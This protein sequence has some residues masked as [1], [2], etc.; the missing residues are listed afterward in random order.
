MNAHGHRGSAGTGSAPAVSNAALVKRLLKLAWVYRLSCVRVLA[1]Q[2]VLLAVGLSGLSLMGTGVDYIRYEAQQG[3]SVQS[4]RASAVGAAPETVPAAHPG[5]AKPPRWPLGLRP[6]ADWSRMRVLFALSGGILLLSVFR[7]GLSIV[8]TLLNNLF[9]Q[10]QLVADLRSRV[11][12]K[13]QRL[14]FKFFDANASGSLINRVTGDAQSVRAF[15]EDAL[16]NGVNLVVSL[17]VYLVYMLR[18]HPGLT[19]ACLATTPLLYLLARR[20]SQ[21]I[22]PAYQ[23]VRDLFDQVIL[24]LGEN[25]QG[26]HVVKGFAREPDQIALFN[27]YNGQCRDKKLWVFRKIVFFQP[28]IELMTS[29]NI[30]V[31]L[32]YGGYLVVLHGRAPDAVTAAAVGIS[33]GQLLIFS[34]LLQQFSGSV[35]G[36]SGIANSIQMSLIGAQ[37]VFEILDTPVEIQSPPDAPRLE[38]ARGRIVFEDVC[39]SYKAGDPVLANLS[40]TIEPGECAVIL[41]QTGAGKSTLLSLIPRFYDADSGCVLVDG[42]DVR[43][44]D[45]ESLRRSVG[46]VFQ[47]SFLFSN[48]VAANIAFGHLEATPAQIE[49]AARIACIH[50]FI[51]T[52]PDG[53]DTLLHESGANLSGGQRQRI[54]LARALL[55]E[56][57][58]LLLDD[59]TA[60]V[61]AETEHEIMQALQNAMEGR[62]TFIVAHRLSILKR[63]D[64]V[65]VLKGGRIV[66]SGTHDELMQT[67]GPYRLA[68]NIQMPDEVSMRL[69]SGVP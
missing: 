16:I 52:L 42:H 57:P 17:V 14:S 3:A 22:R 24:V 20:F 10:G 32:G 34:G 65:I 44:L 63:A 51:V 28:L 56:P 12:D 36:I 58:I 37:R 9:L 50:D 23:T 29:L 18:I 68:A 46:I 69:L 59:P 1:M 5:T 19:V 67:G 54:A 11:Y 4:A 26:M 47:D 66:E 2:V 25:L 30:V 31:M 13:M 53:Y 49:R 62:T 40:F 55:L 60:A 15:V 39:F 21:T 43:T 48:T 8:N 61:D 27:R 6:P 41:G 7:A 35:N 33:I 45:L 64:Q 38:Q